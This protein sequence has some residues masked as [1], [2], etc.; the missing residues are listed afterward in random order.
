LLRAKCVLTL[1][2]F[3]FFFRTISPQT[4]RIHHGKTGSLDSP[5]RS[6]PPTSIPDIQI[7]A[8]PSDFSDASDEDVVDG[9]P[10][11]DVETSIELIEREKITFLPD[12]IDGV[13]GAFVE[14]DYSSVT[15][16][17]Q[18][19]GDV[20]FADSPLVRRYFMNFYKYTNA[21]TKSTGSFSL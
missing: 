12:S 5:H 11:T 9:I 6:R 17:Q 10:A 8:P 15:V 14:Y 20:L 4:R 18:S 19:A 21:T 7:Q 1:R 2:F 3:L 13:G 16:S